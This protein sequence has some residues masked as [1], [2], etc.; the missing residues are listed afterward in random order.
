M[1]AVSLM[2]PAP[3]P[4]ATGR[5][6]REAPVLVPAADHTALCR[7]A[8]MASDAVL[9]LFTSLLGIVLV[10]GS[11]LAFALLLT[12][13]LL[14]IPVLARLDLYPGFG[15]MRAERLRRRVIASL[16]WFPLLALVAWQIHLSPA[17]AL[18][19]G[20]L[21]AHLSP[22]SEDLTRKTLIAAKSWGKPALIHGPERAAAEIIRTLG[23]NP[24]L[25]LLPIR[26]PADLV[27]GTS[28][29]TAILAPGTLI[30]PEN[31][32][33][34]ALY[35]LNKGGILHPL[36]HPEHWLARLIGH[37]TPVNPRLAPWQV[38][39]RTL[40]L[41]VGSMALLIALPLMAIAAAFIYMA[42]PGPVFY[43]QYRRGLH[44]K[45]IRIWKLRSMY[46]DSE[47]RLKTLLQEDTDVA[48]EW[49]TRH[50]LK[51]DPRII[52][53]VGH[54]IR[55]FSIDELPQLVSVL[56]GQLSLVG[57]VFLSITILN[58]TRQKIY[59]CDKMSCRG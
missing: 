18:L 42:D 16:I 48:T 13:S 29:T 12:G 59:V 41:L 22:L 27:A 45:A 38:L 2:P 26:N 31:D 34:S 10:H 37:M 4:A 53:G 58:L 24:Q 39:K 6:R 43:G 35:V 21:F 3:A 5:E 11:S 1:D 47:Q 14:L 52:K 25:G 46:Q 9:M 55:K 32:R 40:D 54:F 49:Q 15:L 20:V 28:V 51:Y 23:Q 30:N 36:Q 50:K 57:P 56:Q 17:A 33:M 44:G 7:K 8:L 19:S